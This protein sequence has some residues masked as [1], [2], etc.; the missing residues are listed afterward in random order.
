[1]AFSDNVVMKINIFGYCKLIPIKEKF[2]VDQVFAV[3][4]YLYM[5]K[6]K[7][8]DRVMVDSKCAEKVRGK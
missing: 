7:E 3:I 6:N 8:Y 4:K 1:M 5:C 2:S